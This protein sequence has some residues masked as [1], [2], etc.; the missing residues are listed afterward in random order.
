MEIIGGILMILFILALVYYFWVALFTFAP[1]LGWIL[2][3]MCVFGFIAGRE[4][5]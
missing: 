3:I 5:D 2:L 4:S 1:I